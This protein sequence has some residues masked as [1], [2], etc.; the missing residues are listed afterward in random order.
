MFVQ[1]DPTKPDFAL[2]RVAVVR[3]FKDVTFVRSKLTEEE[4]K[5]SA[6]EEQ[7]GHRPLLPLLPGEYVITRGVVELTN[8]LNDLAVKEQVERNKNGANR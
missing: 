6:A 8:K 7:R 3:Q 5:T 2:R 1:P 4:K